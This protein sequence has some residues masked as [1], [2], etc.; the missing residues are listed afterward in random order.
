M[1]NTNTRKRGGGCGCGK[2]ILFRG[3]YEYSRRATN[4]RRHRL[5]SRI[6]ASRRPLPRRAAGGAD[7]DAPVIL[8]RVVFVGDGV[9]AEERQEDA[10]DKLPVPEDTSTIEG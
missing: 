3:G 2:G 6:I 4:A 1:G 8:K 10:V 5:K 9:D 7:D